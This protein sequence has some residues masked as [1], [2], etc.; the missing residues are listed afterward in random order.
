MI[1]D[2]AGFAPPLASF[3]T[4][5]FDNTHPQTSSSLR[6]RLD[7]EAFAQPIPADEEMV[8]GRHQF[9][10]IAGASVSTRRRKGDQIAGDGRAGPGS[11]VGDSELKDRVSIGR[12]GEEGR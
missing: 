8:L 12:N 9:Q 7:V 4:S 2:A 6:R 3:E 5:I 10:R 11:V 1:S